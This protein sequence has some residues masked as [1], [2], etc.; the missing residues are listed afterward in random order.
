MSV[1]RKS[2]SGDLAE[3]FERVLDMGIVIEAWFRKS[4]AGIDLITVEARVVVAS[5]ET[6]LRHSD[7]LGTPRLFTRTDQLIDGASRVT[8]ARPYPTRR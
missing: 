8:T 5:I 3:V 2:A 4:L 1:E 6:Y 7:D